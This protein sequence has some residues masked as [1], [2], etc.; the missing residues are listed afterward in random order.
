VEVC[1]SLRMSHLIYGRFVYYDSNSSLTEFKRRSGF[2]A[3]PL[4]RY[5]IPL[6]VRGTIALKLRLHRG[7]GGNVPRS[8]F[9]QFLKI[10]SIWYA[11]RL[12]G[13]KENV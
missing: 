8:L 5:Y 11:R 1:E 10:R 6:T 3:V 7:V 9:R 13:T 2:E 4:P 12:N